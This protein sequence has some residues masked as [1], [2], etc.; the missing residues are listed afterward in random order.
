V[1]LLSFLLEKKILP[2]SGRLVAFLV[3][4]WGHGSSSLENCQIRVGEVC[5][6]PNIV[7]GH[8]SL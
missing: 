4:A 7:I 8:G 5:E 3:I 6:L 2:K 1:K